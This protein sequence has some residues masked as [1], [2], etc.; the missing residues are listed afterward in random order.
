M[1]KSLV[2]IL[3]QNKT[4]NIAIK[5]ILTSA[6]LSIF[7]R[8]IGYFKESVIAY[9]LGISQYV[10]FY[11]LALIYATFFVHPIGGALST[12]LTQKY[13][14]ISGKISK[15]AS[16]NIYIKSQIFGASIMLIIISIQVASLEFPFIQNLIEC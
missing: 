3:V 16:A 13:I 9:Y 14:E 11:V 7:I 2:S 12:L 10:D 6:I 5:A 4:N 15:S 1:I 8:T